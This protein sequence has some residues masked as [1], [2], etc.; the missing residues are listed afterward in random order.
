MQPAQSE[1]PQPKL[2]APRRLGAVA[3]AYP[4]YAKSQRLERDVAVSIVVGTDGRVGDVKV[5][6]SGG[7]DFDRAAVEAA[8]RTVYEP[9]TRDGVPFPFRMSYTYRFR[10]E[11]AQ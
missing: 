9:A 5:L 7:P 3:P 6:K 4:A 8:K 2:T 1:T 11:D 10:I